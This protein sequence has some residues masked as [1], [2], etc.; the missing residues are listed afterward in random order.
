MNSN[1]DDDRLDQ[2]LNEW[3]DQSVSPER[4]EDLRDRIA[5]SMM[6]SEPTGTDVN[7][8]QNG[9]STPAPAEH[10]SSPARDHRSRW[11]AGFVVGTALTLLV[12][13]ALF[14]LIDRNPPVDSPG[15]PVAELTPDYAW[16]RDDQIRN[17]SVLLAEMEQMFDQRVVWLAETGDRIEFGLDRSQS[18]RTTGP[19]DDARLAVRVV[20][21]RRLP[22]NADWQLAWAMD[23]VSRSEELVN[24]VPREAN[25][26]ELRLWAYRLPDGMI[27]V[28]SELQLAGTDAFHARTSGL[29]QNAE[30]VKVATAHSNGTE[31]RVFQTVAVLDGKVI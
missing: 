4:L 13:V 5:S 19:D 27:A 8:E 16:L 31:Y 6:E 25:G 15:L 2:L 23:V 11:A 10:V 29:H 17:K 21:E 14:V 24:V 30:P 1:H 9:R 20:V 7:P 26:N 3:A 12:S 28:D 18:S 22:G